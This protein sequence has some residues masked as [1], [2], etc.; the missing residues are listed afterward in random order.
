MDAEEIR[1]LRLAHPFRPFNLL[2]NDG[3]KLPV[4]KA[5][6]LGMSPDGQLLVHSSLKGGFETFGPNDVKG[7]DFSVAVRGGKRRNGRKKGAA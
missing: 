4:D 3:R 6:Y 5:Y 2:M 7:V 1:K